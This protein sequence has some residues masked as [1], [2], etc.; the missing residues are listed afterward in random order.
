MDARPVEL[1]FVFD[2]LG[3]SHLVQAYRLLVPELR[4]VT[5]GEIGN[6]HDRGDLRTSFIGPAEG[7]ADDREPT[8]G[9]TCVRRR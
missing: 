2:R 4:R 6:D 5:K 8:V 9:S 3:A 7:G 1:D